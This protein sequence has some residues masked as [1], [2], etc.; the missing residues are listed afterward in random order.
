MIADYTIRS[1]VKSPP[2]RE[3]THNLL[4]CDVGI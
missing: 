3:F 2:A 1:A 4:L